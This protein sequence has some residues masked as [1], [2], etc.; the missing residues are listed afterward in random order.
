[1]CVYDVTKTVDILEKNLCD[2]LKKCMFE[3]DESSIG[4]N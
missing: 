2:G 4:V 1:M 3:E